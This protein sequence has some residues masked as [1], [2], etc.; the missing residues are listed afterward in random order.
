M[1]RKGMGPSTLFSTVKMNANATT[2]ED[3]DIVLF[4]RAFYSSAHKEELIMKRII[5]NNVKPTD[6]CRKVKLQI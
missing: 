1:S 4:Y 2:A 6:P 3:N 5:K